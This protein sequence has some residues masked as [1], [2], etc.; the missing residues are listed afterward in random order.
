MQLQPVIY[1]AVLPLYCMANCSP[2]L[3]RGGGGGGGGCRGGV[4]SA[5]LAGGG[6]GMTLL[7]HFLDNG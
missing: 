5:M 3:G 1:T 4:D 2:A 6:G 7:S